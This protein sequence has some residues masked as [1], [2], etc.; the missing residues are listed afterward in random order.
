MTLLISVNIG[1][2]SERAIP[3][4]TCGDAI[5]VPEIVAT[6]L[7]F[8]IHDEVMPTPGAIISTQDPVLLNDAT[9]S[10]LVLAATVMAFG[11]RAGE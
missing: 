4:A 9:E 6:A 11:T 5:E 1:A 8:P 3:P 7:F 10:A 2:L